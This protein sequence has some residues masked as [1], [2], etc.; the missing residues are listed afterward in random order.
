MTDQAAPAVSHRA[1]FPNLRAAALWAAIAA[2]GFFVLA[3]R[4]RG[5]Q[6]I[7][8]GAVGL[9]ALQACLAFLAGVRVGPDRVTLPRPLFNPLPLLVFA[10]SSI[11]LN[12]LRDLT[13]AGR[14]LGFEVVLLTLAE[15]AAPALFVSRPARLAFFAAV[16]RRIP[17]I[18]IYRAY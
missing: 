9:F 16:K 18:R 14:F 2:A 7:A 10:R 11:P 12:S 5:L 8:G 1:N 4:Y 13:S 3:T 6:G 17:D 15:T